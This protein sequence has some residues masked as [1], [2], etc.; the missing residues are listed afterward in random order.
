L[1]VRS[2]LASSRVDH[3]RCQSFVAGGLAD[4][5]PG[6][7]GPSTWHKLLSDSPRVGCGP[8][9]FRGALLAVLLRLTDCPLEGRGPSSPTSGT[10]RVVLCR[11]AKSFASWVLLPLR[12]CLGF[13]PRVGRSVVTI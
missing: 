11:V 5:P 3:S 10:V 7:H 4:R 8:F 9:A 1:R 6:G 2:V 12:D 13:V